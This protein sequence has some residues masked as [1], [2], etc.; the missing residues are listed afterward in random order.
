[1]PENKL[2]DAQMLTAFVNKMVTDKG[3]VLSDD[4][5]QKLRAKLLSELN[6]AIEQAMIRALPDEKLLEL[7]RLTENPEVTDA[8]IEAVFTG[9]GVDFQAVVGRTMN[10]FRQKFLSEGSGETVGE[11]SGEMN[12]RNAEVVSGVGE[13]MS[14]GGEA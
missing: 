14:E 7:E 6:V 3:L 12:E 5:R 9:S 10:D 13:E 2:T 8:A 4:E 11:L 1:M